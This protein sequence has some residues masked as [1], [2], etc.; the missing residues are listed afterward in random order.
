MSRSTDYIM[1]ERC[2][3]FKIGNK[4]NE[5]IGVRNVEV[6]CLSFTAPVQSIAQS[7]MIISAL[8]SKQNGLV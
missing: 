3:V 8:Y 5:M 1:I 6:V 4:K 2:G 7:Y